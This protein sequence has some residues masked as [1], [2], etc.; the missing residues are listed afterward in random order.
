V[1][2]KEEVILV[3]FDFWVTGYGETILDGERVKGEDVLEDAG[4]LLGGGF[5]Q[6]D[7]DEEAFIGADEAEGVTV[8]VAGDQFSV[9][10]HKRS[11][12]KASSYRRE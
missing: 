7:P 1:H 11:N 12:H 8:K 2:D 4:C 10:E 5:K 3:V 9:I 6:V